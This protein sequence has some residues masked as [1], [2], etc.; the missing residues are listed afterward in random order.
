M[1]EPGK[2]EPRHSGHAVVAGTDPLQRD[3]LRLAAIRQS[4]T[5]PARELG[6]DANSIIADG[7]LRLAGLPTYP[8]DRLSR[9]ERMHC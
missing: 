6:L 8:L 3:Q 4:D 5:A 1:A 2:L 7:F 9:Y